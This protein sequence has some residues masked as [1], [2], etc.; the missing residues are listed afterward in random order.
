MPG[1]LLDSVR[2]A[3]A[4]TSNSAHFVKVQDDT[5]EQYAAS[6]PLEAARAP[7]LDP[8]THFLGDLDSTLA[9]VVQL[10]AI[11]FGSGY[12]PKLKKRPGLSG[13][14]TVASCLKEVFAAHG[15]LTSRQL[16]SLSQVDCAGMFGQE[17][18]A[19]AAVDE[20]MGLFAAALNALGGYVGARFGG[21]F[22]ALVES[23][24]GS[25]EELVG[26]LVEMPFYQD[27][28][29]YK[30]AQLTAADL[31]VAQVATF[32]DLDRLTI[33]A[34]NLV[35]HVLRVDGILQYEPDLLD[36][37]NREELIPSGSTEER[38]IRA[39]AVHAVELIREALHRRTHA[40]TSMELDYVLWNRGQQ[41]AYKSQSRHR[42]RTV[43]Y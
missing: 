26:I 33:F 43:F 30:R 17:F 11:N 27:V 24:R 40:V 8:A 1:R 13:Y 3:A 39:G 38:E 5:I 25:A 6:L 28:G 35:P 4:L 15:Q 20:L 37:I 18:G 14:F 31:S 29:F 19:D 7:T 21:S 10:D 41:P 16:Q 12:F 2:A 32:G 9:Y 22:G 34:D 36:R 23:A 42:T